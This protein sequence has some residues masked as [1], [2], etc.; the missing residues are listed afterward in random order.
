LLVAKGGECGDDA[1][2]LHRA[3]KIE[4]RL[5]GTALGERVDNRQDVEFALA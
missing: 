5:L 3:G 4:Q 1:V 2:F